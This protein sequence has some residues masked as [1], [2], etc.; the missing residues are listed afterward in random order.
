M[1]FRRDR[2]MRGQFI[3]II[4][5]HQEQGGDPMSSAGLVSS[6]NSR[7]SN[8]C[9]RRVK[10]HFSPGA[11][12]TSLSTLH[13]PFR[14]DLRAMVT[15]LGGENTSL[16][17]LVQL[18]KSSGSKAI[19]TSSVDFASSSSRSS[20]VSMDSIL[21]SVGCWCSAGRLDPRVGSVL[22]LAALASDPLAPSPFRFVPNPCEVDADCGCGCCGVDPG[23][24]IP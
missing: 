18:A 3:C 7:T 8:W 9:A 20:H 16:T 4:C 21:P 17:A 6:I 10:S 1:A 2:S 5:D 24:T 19:T 15:T 23:A 12:S 22:V 11:L 14:P 13:P